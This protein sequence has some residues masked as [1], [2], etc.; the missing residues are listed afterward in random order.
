MTLLMPSSGLCE[1]TL[2]PLMEMQIFGQIFCRERRYCFS[3]WGVDK[4]AREVEIGWA[5]GDIL[6]GLKG[7]G[8]GPSLKPKLVG[9][10]KGGWCWAS[11]RKT[12]FQHK[13]QPKST[14]SGVVSSEVAVLLT[15][16]SVV[17]RQDGL[18]LACSI[19]SPLQR[20]FCSQP[21]HRWR[22]LLSWDP[23][24]GSDFAD[25]RPP[26]FIGPSLEPVKSKAM[27]AQRRMLTFLRW[28][29]RWWGKL[30]CLWSRRFCL[31]SELSLS[32]RLGW[33]SPS[34]CRVC[35]LFT[36]SILFSYRVFLL[37][38]PA[39]GWFPLYRL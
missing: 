28:L 35:L 12:K 6:E 23:C 38:P 22:L 33:W 37:W 25:D 20:L 2:R 26:Q 29:L 16:V 39:G 3:P 10:H 34:F 31:S 27:R 32:L 5:L 14:L 7:F 11:K 30:G 15:N 19:V 24:V 9:R 13:S 8:F 36:V 1:A 21:S 18:L 4:S 17:V